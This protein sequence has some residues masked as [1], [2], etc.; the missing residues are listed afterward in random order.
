MKRSSLVVPTFFNFIVLLYLYFEL[1][2]HSRLFREKR[3]WHLSTD[4]ESLCNSEQHCNML[5]WL[6]ARDDTTLSSTFSTV[7]V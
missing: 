4:L 1:P 6:Q 3:L 7:H 5:Q 2:G